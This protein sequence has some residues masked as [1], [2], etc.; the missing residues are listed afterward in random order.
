MALNADEG[1]RISLI[2]IAKRVRQFLKTAPH[3]EDENREDG[4]GKNQ[5]E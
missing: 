4:Y 1:D 2:D 3:S 5:V